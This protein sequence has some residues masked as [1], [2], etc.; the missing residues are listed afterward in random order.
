MQTHFKF[1]SNHPL[2]CRGKRLR[3][4]LP[5]KQKSHNKGINLFPKMAGYFSVHIGSSSRC[6]WKDPGPVVGLRHSTDG[7][8][9]A[10]RQEETYLSKN[11]QLSSSSCGTHTHFS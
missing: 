4:L 1:W 3:L 10:Q 6:R 7:E 2:S 8:I 11:T 9:E 5:P